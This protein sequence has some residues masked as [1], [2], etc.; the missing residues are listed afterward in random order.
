MTPDDPIRGFSGDLGKF[1]TSPGF[2]FG[3]SELLDGLRTALSRRV[4]HPLTT[5]H[6]ARI[7]GRAVSTTHFWFATYRHPHLLGFVALL[8]FLAPSERTA[9]LASFCRTLPTLDDPRFVGAPGDLLLLRNLLRHRQGLTVITGP[10]DGER[11]FVLTAIGHSYCQ[12]FAHR[13]FPG[14]IDLHLPR[15]FVPVPAVKY[16][17]ETTGT[18]QVRKLTLDVWP[19]IATSKASLLL[20]NRVWSQVPAVRADLLRSARLKHV[21]LADEVAP[22]L[23]TIKGGATPLLHVV[24]SAC[25]EVADGIRIVCRR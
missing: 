10:D 22:D 6:L 4:G 1:V 8:E 23:Q 5:E 15:R 7:M 3:A 11:T 24:V 16:L 2:P 20:F 13:R 9:F 14:G 21:V 18:N 25:S 12:L 19:K 17:S